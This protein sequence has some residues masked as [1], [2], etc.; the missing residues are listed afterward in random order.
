[1]DGD[2]GLELELDVCLAYSIPHSTFLSWP[3]SD[4][5]KAIWHH[6]RNRQ[7]C[8]GCGTRPEEWDPKKGGHRDAYHP[9][10]VRCPG[11]VL[12]DEMESRPAVADAPGTYVV[13]VR[14]QEV[15]R[16]ES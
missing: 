10:P 15:S 5:D 11:C 6:I 12:K 4:R 14:N 3:A 13:L 9:K 2:P 16:A 7:A 1:L 8:P